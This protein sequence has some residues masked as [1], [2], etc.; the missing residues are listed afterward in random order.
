MQGIAIS[1]AR[2]YD[3]FIFFIDLAARGVA[4]IAMRRLIEIR[5]ELNISQRD[6]ARRSEVDQSTISLIEG[7]HRPHER[8]ALKVWM[9]INAIRQERR[10]PP[11]AFDEIRWNSALAARPSANEVR[12]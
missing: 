5:A 2:G 1:S 10:M 9:A 4:P 6:L 3:A 12:G 8:T 11:L 7:G